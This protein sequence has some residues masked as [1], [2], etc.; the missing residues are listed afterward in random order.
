[1]REVSDSIVLS[2]EQLSTLQRSGTLHWCWGLCAWYCE[3]DFCDYKGDY[4]K[5]I[6]CKSTSHLQKR[7][8]VLSLDFSILAAIPQ[9]F[10]IFHV[11]ERLWSWCTTNE[12]AKLEGDLLD[13]A[14]FPS[15]KSLTKTL[16]T[17]DIQYHI[18]KNRWIFQREDSAPGGPWEC[19]S[20]Q[21][22]KSQS[23][24]EFC[25]LCSPWSKR[26]LWAIFQPVCDAFQWSSHLALNPLVF[27]FVFW[28]A[29]TKVNLSVTFSFNLQHSSR[30][31]I[32][33]RHPVRGFGSQFLN[34]DWDP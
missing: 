11:T 9:S 10:N 33:P 16:G 1:M 24:S 29:E 3:Q 13:L 21:V 18:A 31:A 5:E 25:F 27:S 30:W 32:K 19:H 17:P 6:L 26:K 12:W 4:G 14:G 34:E 28:G 15:K 23:V 20:C 2:S 7:Y 8:G 22:M